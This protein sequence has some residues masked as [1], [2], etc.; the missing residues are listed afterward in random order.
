MKKSIL[1]NVIITIIVTLAEILVGIFLIAWI[2]PSLIADATWGLEWKNPC[3]YFTE[4]QYEKTERISDLSL[5]VERSFWADKHELSLKYCPILLNDE[6]FSDLLQSKDESYSEYIACGYVNAL[7]E[8]DSK[9]KAVATAFKYL[10]IEKY[11]LAYNPVRL[12]CSLAYQDSDYDTLSLILTNLQSVENKTSE[13]LNDVE[14]L[15]NI[16]TN[17]G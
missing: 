9:Q 12:L 4:K 17:K 11:S 10:N 3:V 13:V 1:K 14:R 2:T 15:S 16:I 7:Y 6:N 8:S 5:L